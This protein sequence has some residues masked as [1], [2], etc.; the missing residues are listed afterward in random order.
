MTPV[1]I[2]ALVVAGFFALL[3]LVLIPA[4]SSIRQAAQSVSLLTEFIT[5]ELKPTVKELNGVLVELKTITTGIAQQTDD[6]KKLMGAL[7]ETG[8]HVSTINR[9]LGLVSGV[10]G[11]AGAVATGAK[12]AG[13]YFFENYLKRKMKGV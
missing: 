9:A 3:V 11:Q 4:I 2:A 10:I 13:T 8:T 7:G 1:S 12:V 5:R 6:V